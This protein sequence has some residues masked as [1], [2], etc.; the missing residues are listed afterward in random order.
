MD[1]DQ[2][3]D[4]LL[5][6]IRRTNNVIA[7]RILVLLED[8]QAEHNISF[9]KLKKNLPE[10]YLP[11]IEASDYFCPQKFAVYRK[12]VLDLVGDAF[13]DQ[14]NILTESSNKFGNNFQ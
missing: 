3:L 5:F 4:I 8:L 12:R 11:I 9:E 2:E 1:L 7:K 6:Q 10:E 14:T 13:R